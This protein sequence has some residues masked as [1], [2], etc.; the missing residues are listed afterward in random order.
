[1]NYA[2]IAA[3]VRKR[4]EAFL[5]TDVQLYRFVERTAVRGENID[6]FADP[7]TIKARIINR[8]GNDEMPVASQYRAVQQVVNTAII[9]MQVPYDLEVTLN[10]YVVVGENKY[11][12]VHIPERHEL[13]GSFVLYLQKRT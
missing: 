7:V 1:M 10:D 9:R 12:I 3:E 4:S 11:D 2:A 5:L 13:A 8:G 6:H